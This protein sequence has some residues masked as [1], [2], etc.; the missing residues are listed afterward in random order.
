MTQDGMSSKSLT[1]RN[2]F[3]MNSFYLTNSIYVTFAEEG[4]KEEMLYPKSFYELKSTCYENDAIDRGWK[5]GLD[6]E[7]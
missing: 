7:D 6:L 4:R 3:L 1:S 2:E 5:L